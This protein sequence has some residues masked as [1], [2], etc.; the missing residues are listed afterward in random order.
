MIT[1]GINDYS[2]LEDPNNTYIDHIDCWGK[3]LG[4]DKVLIRSVPT[5]HPQYDEIEATAAYFANKNSIYGTPYRVYRVYTPQNEPYS[6]SYIRNDKVFVPIMNSQNDQAALQAYRDAMPGYKVFGF[7]GQSSTPWQSTDALHCRVHEMADTEML[8]LKHIPLQGNVNVQGSYNFVAYAKPF[9]SQQ[10]LQDSVLMY[11]RI[12]PNPVTPYTPLT[13]NNAMGDAYSVSLT[14]P[15]EGST[16]EYYIYAASNTGKREYQPFIGPADAFKFY[17]GSQM[18]AQ[19]AVSPSSL[20]FTAMKDTEDT[21]KITISSSGQIGVNYTLAVA[22]DIN[23]TL[24]FNLNN[25][26]A[27]TAWNS[28]TLTEDN[29]TTF[30]VSSEGQVSNVVL[31]YQWNTDQYYEEG[32]VWI[33]SPSGTSYRAGYQQLDGYYKLIIPVFTGETLNGSWKV[34]LQDSHG[35]G[36]HQATNVVV[37]IV[38]QNP[39]GNWLSVSTP[40]GVVAAGQSAEID[41]IADAQGMPLGGYEGRITLYSNDPDQPAIQIPV[42]FT[43]TIN[44]GINSNDLLADKVGVNPNPFSDELKVD[45]ELM[46]EGVVKISLFN[47]TGKEIYTSEYTVSAGKQQI[48]IPATGINQG[49]YFM[50]V[51]TGDSIEN[52]KLIK[53]R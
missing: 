12:N 14:A 9:G 43:V 46:K 52:F 22:T 7:L 3:Y 38:K 26:P 42:T 13:M 30:S 45:L 34:W 24:S 20:A 8:Y 44:T 35:D 33:Q 37:K 5:S 27:Q 18:S 47:S 11:Y 39:L 53:G 10:V 16:V 23:D 15:E 6:N 19:V 32:S 41:V 50:K 31:S 1:F 21:E 17:V 4:P 36:G 48:V 49:I 51:N 40:N 2:V 29:W 25:S 28:N